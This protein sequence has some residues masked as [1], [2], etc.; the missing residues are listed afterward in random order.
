MKKRSTTLNI[1]L[2]ILKLQPLMMA[3][4]E[5]GWGHQ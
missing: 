2:P 5:N 4:L 1:N 3:I